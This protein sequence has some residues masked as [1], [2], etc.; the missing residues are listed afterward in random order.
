VESARPGS[1]RAVGYYHDRDIRSDNSIQGDEEKM[2]GSLVLFWH[3]F[4]VVI[5]LLTMGFYCIF[6]TYNLIRVLIGVELLIKAVTLLIITAG[7]VT[8]HMALAQAIVITLIVVEVVF[9]VVA[10]GVVI[11]LHRHNGTL[12]TRDTRRLKG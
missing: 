4:I 2:N 9:I 1:V 12:D 7:Y 8:G 10:T 5:M 6:M 3:L 11:G